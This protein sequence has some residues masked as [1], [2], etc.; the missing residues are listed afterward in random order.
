[1]KHAASLKCDVIYDVIISKV[2]P[3]HQ[4]FSVTFMVCNTVFV[5]WNLKDIC[6]KMLVICSV[7]SVVSHFWFIIQ[8]DVICNVTAL[9][10]EPWTLDLVSL[11]LDTTSIVTALIPRGLDIS[12]GVSTVEYTP[13][14]RSFCWL[15]GTTIKYTTRSG[16]WWK[17]ATRLW[18]LLCVCT[19]RATRDYSLYMTVSYCEDKLFRLYYPPIYVL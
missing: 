4:S 3:Q 14:D 9:T 13:C 1:M 6:D 16:S 10:P 17:W 11:L 7:M 15:Y 12:P 2:I 18:G 8:C 19:V 5:T